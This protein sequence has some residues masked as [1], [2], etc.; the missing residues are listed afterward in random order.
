MEFVR[1]IKAVAPDFVV[2]LPR[3][4]SS[5]SPNGGAT[6]DLINHAW[7]AS[8][9]S[10]GLLDRLDV[11]QWGGGYLAHPAVGSAVG[12]SSSESWANEYA[13][14]TD[15]GWLPIKV[16]V[17]M[18]AITLGVAGS[19]SASCIPNQARTVL[20]QGLGGF[21]VWFA[22]VVDAATG[23]TAIS[24]PVYDASLSGSHAQSSW[25][26]ALKMMAE[27]D[28]SSGRLSFV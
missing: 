28:T 1:S 21:I 2:S 25:A 20:Q 9:K 24:Y 17:P 14:A 19:E 11:M 27:A 18:S 6:N 16:D 8:Q 4:G 5:Q 26:E 12:C 13:H 3:A 22:S 7:D 23:N 15:K 10:L